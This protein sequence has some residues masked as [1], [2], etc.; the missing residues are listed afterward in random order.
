M[1]VERAYS[2]LI[3][4]AFGKKSCETLARQ[5]S[6]LELNSAEERAMVS[7]IFHSAI[8]LLCEDD[9]ELPQVQGLLPLLQR[10]VA[11]HH[12]GLLPVLKEVVELLFQENL[13]KLLFATETFAMGLNMPARTVIFSDLSKF[14]GSEFRY[15]SSGEYIQM[16]GRAGR[17][18]LDTRGVV[19]QM[20]DERTDLVKVREMLEGSADSLSSKFH[21]SYNML[22]NCVRVETADV[23]LLISKSF[24]TFQL[25]KAL[26]AMQAQ[27]RALVARLATPEMAIADEALLT[28]LLQAGPCCTLFRMCMW[29]M[30]HPLIMCM[31]HVAC[32][33][34][35]V[36][37][38]CACACAYGSCCTP[39]ACCCTPSS[40]ACCMLHVACACACAYGSCC[41][42]FALILSIHCAPR[43]CRRGGPSCSC[44]MPCAASP[45]SPSTCCPSCSSAGWR[46]CASRCP[47]SGARLRPPRPP[48][49]RRG[50]TRGSGRRRPSRWTGGGA[51]W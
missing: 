24:Y 2:P 4:F 44:A 1:I 25:Q 45:T 29:T 39:F 9:R 28:E 19:I 23:E 51:C 20:A 46:S 38:A 22:L 42:P 47:G 10:G 34:L 18:G 21:L 41:T 7:D 37:C 12:S 13:V 5:M 33:M 48:R 14:D 40:C 17:R 27:Q 35:H 31:L 15:L 30:L 3:V 36:A 11:V 50:A 43:C 26:P 16:S 49:H 8:D 6:A 32:C